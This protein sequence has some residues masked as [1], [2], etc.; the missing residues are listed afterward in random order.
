M[1]TPALRSRLPCAH[2]S[3]RVIDGGFEV[4]LPALNAGTDAVISSARVHVVNAG[5]F[6][7]SVTINPP[8]SGV[9]TTSRPKPP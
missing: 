1:P 8:Q 5:R 7:T 6:G 2:E 9:S 3:R 4:L